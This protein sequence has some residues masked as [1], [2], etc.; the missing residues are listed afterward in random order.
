MRPSLQAMRRECVVLWR[1]FGTALYIL[2][3]RAWQIQPP[4]RHAIC[5]VTQRDRSILSVHVGAAGTSRGGGGGN[6][7]ACCAAGPRM[8]RGLSAGNDYLCEEFGGE[9]GGTPGD[10]AAH[11]G[12][13]MSL[14]R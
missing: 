14:V 3:G 7:T 2:A 4:P 11:G 12:E 1:R 6:P 5:S 9:G 10:A 13:E 8:L